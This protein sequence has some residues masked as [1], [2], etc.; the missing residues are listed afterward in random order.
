SGPRGRG[1]PHVTS[2]DAVRLLLAVLS[3]NPQIR[4]EEAARS[5]WR[6]RYNH[7]IREE[8]IVGTP[9]EQVRKAT[10]LG[11]PN[12]ETAQRSLGEYLVSVVNLAR[13]EQGRAQIR[14]LKDLGVWQDNSA[15]VT[16]VDGR[17]WW[18]TPPKRPDEIAGPE[19]IAP[20]RTMT[21]VPAVILAV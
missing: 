6:L 12:L 15:F 16:S 13:T 1:A 4:A 14:G 20:A 21:L 17:T 11:P 5:L 8:I 18:F 9:H 10:K 3:G 2:E 7:E 19:K